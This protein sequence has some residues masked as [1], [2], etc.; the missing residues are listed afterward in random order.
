MGPPCFHE[1]R[2]FGV[3]RSA[4]RGRLCGDGRRGRSII[5]CISE[6][7]DRGRDIGRSHGFGDVP[8]REPFHCTSFRTKG[9]RSDPD[10]VDRWNEIPP[11]V[12][13]RRQL[14]CMTAF[15]REW[16][17]S[18]HDESTQASISGLPSL[19]AIPPL[20]GYL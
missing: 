12:Q 19:A 9:I 15:F 1:G 14:P 4:V 10:N 3:R 13:L 6:G 18:R 7:P 11:L 8:V 20:R 2:F 5:P 17:F 16:R